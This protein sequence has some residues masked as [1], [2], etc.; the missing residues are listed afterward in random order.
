MKIWFSGNK[1]KWEFF[2]YLIKSTDRD[3]PV[4]K[5]KSNPRVY[6]KTCDGWIWRSPRFDREKV[7]AIASQI[8]HLDTLPGR[9]KVKLRKFKTMTYS[10]NVECC[11]GQA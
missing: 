1:Q 9:L 2:N 4:N 10:D 8:N 11:D 3:W 5:D 7:L 6:C